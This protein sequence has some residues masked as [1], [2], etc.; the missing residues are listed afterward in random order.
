MYKGIINNGSLRG[1]MTGR[2]DWEGFTGVNYGD[3]IGAVF[4]R[5]SCEVFGPIFSRFSYEVYW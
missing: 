1:K 5:F 3:Y 2:A 4:S